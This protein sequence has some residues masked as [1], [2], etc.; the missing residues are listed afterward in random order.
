MGCIFCC[1][2][3]KDQEEYT[4]E[5]IERLRLKV[6]IYSDGKINRF[7]IIRNIAYAMNEIKAK[8]IDGKTKQEIVMNIIKEFLEKGVFPEELL[9]DLI[10]NFI[11]DIYISFKKLFAKGCCRKK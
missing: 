11:D 4:M 7:N 5:Q 1:C 6:K 10:K 8:N 2:G 3:K 9:D